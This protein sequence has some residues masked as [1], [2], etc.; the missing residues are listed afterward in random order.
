MPAA[1]FPDPGKSTGH[2]HPN[3][4]QGYFLVLRYQAQLFD[5]LDIEF[6]TCGV[7]AGH[8]YA[9]AMAQPFEG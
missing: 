5:S 7:T 2:D 3:D 6:T 4:V 8:V 1:S 9:G